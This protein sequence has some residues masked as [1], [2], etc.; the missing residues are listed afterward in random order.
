MRKKSFLLKWAIGIELILFLF[1]VLP[2]S[3]INQ[4]YGNT[5]LEIAQENFID[6][7]VEA[8]SNLEKILNSKELEGFVNA[9]LISYYLFSEDSLVYWSNN[10][11]SI[12]ATLSNSDIDKKVFL[13]GDGYYYLQKSTYQ[14]NVAISAILLQQKYFHNN[15]YLQ[16]G[17][18]LNKQLAK[19]YSI[20]TTTNQGIKFKNTNKSVVF[21]I[22]SDSPNVEFQSIRDWQ[23]SMY[24][25]AIVLFLFILV[26]WIQNRSIYWYIGAILLLIS[27]RWIGYYFH[28]PEFLYTSDLFSPK[29]FALN[30]WLPN[31]GDT[32]LHLLFAFAVLWLTVIRMVRK[33]LK[34][35]GFVLLVV[36]IFIFGSFITHL[37]R[38]LVI[39]STISFDLSNLYSL[40][41]YSYLGLLVMCFLLCAIFLLIFSAFSQ[42][43]LAFKKG[44]WVLILLGILNYALQYF[45]GERNIIFINWPFILMLFVAIIQQ[46]YEGRYNLTRSLFLIVLLSFISSYIILHQTA[47]KERRNMAVMAQKLSEEKDVIAEYLF[48]KS[49]ERMKS[50]STL[51]SMVEHYWERPN[52]IN[53]YITSNYF[54]GFWQGYKLQFT[55][56]TAVDRLFVQPDNLELNCLQFFDE[57]IEKEGSPTGSYPLFLMQ[58]ETGQISYLSRIAFEVDSSKV[59]FFAEFNNKRLIENEGYPELLLD[60]KEISRSINLGELS[61][62][63]YEHNELVA[64]AGD[65]SFSSIIDSLPIEV[66]SIFKVKDGAHN[67]LYYR[68]NSSTILELVGQSNDWLS[69]FTTFSYVFTIMALLIVLIALVLKKFPIHVEWRIRDFTTKIQLFIIG[70]LLLSIGMFSIA[71]TYYIKKQYRSKNDKNISEKLRSVLIEVNQK[72]GDE[73]VLNSS[74]SEYMMQVLV[75][76]SNVFYTDINLYG[77]N[78]EL[79]ATSRPEIFEIRLKAQLMDAKAYHMMAKEKRRIFINNE[80]IGQLS[81]LSAYVPFFNNDG[82]FLAYLNLP[83]F[84]KQNE[85]EEEISSFLVSSINIYVVIFCFSIILSVIFA[86]YISKPLQLLRENISKVNIG[87]SN[88]IIAWEGSDEISSLVKEYNRMVVK[89]ADSADLLARTERAGA[90][91]E[92]AKQVAHEIKNPLTPMKLSI[93]YLKRA[94]DD[95]RADLSQRIDKTTETLIQQIDALAQIAD[96]FSNFAKMPEAQKQTLDFLPILTNAVNLYDELENISLETD[97]IQTSVSIDKDQLLRVF[98]NI[99]KNGFQAVPEDI[100]P[101]IRIT[102]TLNELTNSY[103]IRIEDNGQGIS[104]SDYHRI[105]VPNFTSKS[106]GMGLGLAIVKNIIEQSNGRVY[107]ESEL[108]AG[109][110]FILVLPRVAEE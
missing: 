8:S 68:L 75:K 24:F 107:F 73:K 63:K 91:K 18:T 35:V 110:T 81:Y 76:F 36:S 25:L 30:E 17:F 80:H 13:L 79:I 78:G 60:Q 23:I 11:A 57:R 3:W 69:A 38:G 87:S 100:T 20:D 43:K 98:N 72:L 71:S 104:P 54:K 33:S 28:F 15:A 109:T 39:S 34:M 62:A 97:L 26:S 65:Y 96:E 51:L 64:S 56:C 84:A 88:E 108:G 47:L 9:G 29:I 55:F 2:K 45:L 59:Y 53:D 32:I 94:S 85:L 93:Q 58:S 6:L 49:A 42:N 102:A 14:K 1:L 41:P 77:S 37:F 52:V 86:N 46:Y 67:H 74:L 82:K 66:G 40:N 31:L 48:A 7:E 50:D 70:I 103:Q 16:N 106:S 21:S 90:W 101:K 12:N 92:M 99:I 10:N 5:Q 89:L 105:F 27:L 61:F 44:I 83:Y 19:L 4:Q 22:Q 95:Q